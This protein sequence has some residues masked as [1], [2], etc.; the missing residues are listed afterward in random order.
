MNDTELNQLLDTWKDPPVPVSFRRRTRA[1]FAARF[2]KTA[3]WKP[4]LRRSLFAAAIAALLLVAM[5]AIP[6]TFSPQINVPYNVFSLFTKYSS[7][8]SQ[9]VEM[10]TVSYNDENGREI[11]L[12]RQMP[13]NFIGS[14]VG[15]ALDAV[16]RI[17]GPRLRPLRA[18]VHSDPERVD[19]P[20]KVLV[21]CASESCIGLESFAV[22]SVGARAGCATEN[23]VARETIRDFPTVAVRVSVSPG[24]RLTV[25][26]AP[27]LACYA[28]KIADE[29]LGA[30]GSFHL[31]RMKQALK[32]RQNRDQR[33]VGDLPHF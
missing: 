16:Q 2:E 31:A 11:L 1:E 25:W 30:D 14:V 26:M 8:G 10:A 32:V 15:R 19:P 5:Q 3:R 17:A 18:A 27:D 7:D 12:G 13:G 9:T 29:R 6:Q 28:M 22:P 23:V 21:G 33:H 20:P 4:I 24:R